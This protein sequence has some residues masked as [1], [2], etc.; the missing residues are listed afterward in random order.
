MKGV[1]Y[2]GFSRVTVGRNTQKPT[3]YKSDGAKRVITIDDSRKWVSTLRTISHPVYE[4]GGEYS[5]VL[6]S[7]TSIV[8]DGV[9]MNGTETDRWSAV[10]W[11]PFADVVFVSSAGNEGTNVNEL[12][13]VFLALGVNNAIRLDGGTAA[14]MSVDGRLVNPLTGPLGRGLGGSRRVAW[15]F[16]TR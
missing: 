1:D 13:E 15:V 4:W 12:C 16:A 3:N 2:L 9:C 11:T 14:S 8:R 7:S 10:G 5:V 6:S